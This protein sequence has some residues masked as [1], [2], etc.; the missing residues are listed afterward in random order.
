MAQQMSWARSGSGEE[1]LVLL[2]GIGCTREDFT[3]VRSELEK[4]FEVLSPDLP[5]HGRSSTLASTPT[6][7]ALADALEADLDELG[8]ERLHLLGNSL[9]ARLALELAARGRA[10]SVVAISPSGVN[11]PIERAYQG[12]V[13]TANRL[14]MRTLRPLIEPAAGSQLGRAVL[15]AG[16]RST[17]WRASEAEAKALRGGFAGAEKF[18]SALLWGVLLDLPTGLRRI[19]VPVVLAQGTADLIGGGQTP[20]FLFLIPGSRFVP[21]W[22]AGHAPQSDAP[23]AIIDLVHRAAAAAASHRRAGG[24]HTDTHQLQRPAT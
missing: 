5:G 8:L 19:K 6:V 2:H 14:A 11:W 10:L 7:S 21:L 20:R 23:T 4:S 1:P 12:L 3:A 17:P 22:G 13:M 9:G 15:L 18:W 24:D 16:M